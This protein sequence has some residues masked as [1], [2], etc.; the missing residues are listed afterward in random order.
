MT[1]L[2][3]YPQWLGPRL[4]EDSFTWGEALT[5]S[6]PAFGEQ[7]TFHDSVW[8][9]LHLHL[10]LTGG[11]TA[12]IR[13]DSFW[14]EGKVPHPGS[15]VAEWPILLVR[16][17]DVGAVRLSGFVGS[18]W[19]SRTIDA[20]ETTDSTAGRHRTSFD[21][22]YSGRVEIDHAPPVQILCFDR[23]GEALKLPFR[24]AV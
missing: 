3:Y 24:D 12:I 9:G 13:L 17:S 23:S 5:T 20:S 1:A 8:I 14:T 19:S 7:Y 2:S 21:D 16:F 22:I 10:D 18:D 6:L 11:A 15:L 4:L